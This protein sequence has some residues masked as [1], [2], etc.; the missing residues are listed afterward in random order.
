MIVMGGHGMFWDHP[1][2]FNEALSAFVAKAK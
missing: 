1:D 2:D